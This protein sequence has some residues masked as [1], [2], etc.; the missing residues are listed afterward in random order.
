MRDN[1]FLIRN[2]T[3]DEVDS[4][5]IEWAAKEGWN[6][7]IYDADCFYSADPKGFFAGFFKDEAIACISVVSYDSSFGFLGFYIVKPYYRGKGYGIEIWNK[8]LAYLKTQNIGL[9]GVIEQ[10]E[11]YKKS[12]F[13]F[14]YNN[15]R[16]EGKAKL[17]SE[18][19]PEI[20]NLS[21]VPFDDI[22]HYDNGIFPVSRL[23]F[24]KC[25]IQQPES[26]SFAA[27]D[28]DKIVGYCVVRKCRNGYKYGP[29]FANTAELA[30]KL[31]ITANNYLKPETKIFLDIPE[32]NKAA[33]ILAEKHKMTKVFETARMYTKSE[34][35]IDINKVFGVTSFELG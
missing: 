25:W 22:L 24:L 1:E 4:I 34:P 23:N 26:L 15:I 14:A 6:P 30:N 29:L 7:G 19:F 2:I 18:F 27:I 33:L 11:N 35:D 17:T 12:G 20:V 32:K 8:A 10:Q 3:K 28:K 31:F 16:Y 13:S 21:K 9:D 5:A